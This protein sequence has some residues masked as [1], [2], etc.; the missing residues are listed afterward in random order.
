[1]NSG[2]LGQGS[3]FVVTL[4]L[5]EHAAAAEIAQPATLALTPVAARVL[6]IQDNEEAA[7]VLAQLLR[8][9]GHEVELAL[10]GAKGLKLV[11]KFSPEVILCDLGLPGVDGYEVAA[12]IRK[13][14]LSRTPAMIALT[15]YGSAKDHKSALAAGFDLH[16]VKP[17]DPEVLLRLIDS[18]MKRE[19]STTSGRSSASGLAA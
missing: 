19:D 13:R 9:S 11:E 15:G 7:D 10:D 16:V 6:M 12:R 8:L 3:E 2:G 5:L 4:P 18:A 14:P 1:V 17:A